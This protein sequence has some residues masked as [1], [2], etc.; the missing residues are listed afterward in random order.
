MTVKD[1][2]D[3][4]KEDIFIAIYNNRGDRCYHSG[5]SKQT[6]KR[7]DTCHIKEISLPKMD[8]HATIIYLV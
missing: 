8:G 2:L 5:T 4:I 3:V 7:L 6:P 1:F